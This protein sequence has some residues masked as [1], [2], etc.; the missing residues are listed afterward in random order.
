MRVTAGADPGWTLPLPVDDGE[1]VTPEGACWLQRVAG[2]DGFWLEVTG[3]PTVELA[4]LARRAAPLM[5]AVLEGERHRSMLAEE[6][7]GRYEEIDLLYAISEILGQTVRLDE[8]ARTIVKEVA[9]VV[10]ARRASIMVHDPGARVLRTVA[11]AGFIAGP[12][13]AVPVDDERSVAARVFRE[14]RPL[15]HD[16][17][18]EAAPRPRGS[19]RGEG[20]LSVPIIYAAPG[21]EPRCVGV[22]NL[23]DRVGGDRFT[24]GDRKL[25]SAIASQIGAAIE[26][27]RLAQRDREQQRLRRE[28]ELAHDLQLRL[29]P[30]PSV[31]QGEA[32]VAAECRPA[33]EVGGDFYTFTR[34][35]RSRVGVMLGDVSSHGFP[36]ALVMALVLSA[37]GIHG[38]GAATPDG[39]LNAIL[40]SL[41]DELGSTEMYVSMFYGVLDRD[42]GRLHFANAGHPYAFRVPRRGAPERLAATA[43]PLGLAPRV[44]GGSTETPWDPANDLLVLWTDGLVEARGA[45]GTPFGEA[46]LLDAVLRHRD[47]TPAR[48]V[49]AV[50]AECDAFAPA[51]SDDRTLLVLHL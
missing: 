40:S 25:V 12:E 11:A 39:T 38:A 17:A 8:A 18:N 44:D 21:G 3:R 15:A 26:N 35:D 22:I 9:S 28:L 49:E 34:L 50:L 16:P 23:T 48:I 30:P 46:R 51:P 27:A 7:A 29:L 47:D 45:D 13:E 36:A 41:A 4:A 5:S 14:R 24:N 2:V 19:Y 37:A 1:V 31:L 6:L 20:Y 10:G 32:Q 43:P 42:A 33:E